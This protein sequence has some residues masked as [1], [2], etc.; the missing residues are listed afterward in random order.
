MAR[1]ISIPP[2][3]DASPSQVIP[4]QF[5]IYVLPNNWPVPIYTPGWREALWELSVLPKNTTQCSR[6]GFK[7]GPLAPGTSALIIRQARLPCSQVYVRMFIPDFQDLD[8]A[9]IDH[10]NSIPSLET[11]PSIDK[12]IFNF[13]KEENSCYFLVY[14]VSVIPLLYILYSIKLERKWRPQQF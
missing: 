9:M 13:S 2:G 7:P 10:R 12:I 1:S 14:I 6:P 8:G 3:R 4:P 5:V 11:T